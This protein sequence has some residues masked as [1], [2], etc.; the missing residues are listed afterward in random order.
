[1]RRS[2][3]ADYGFR[4]RSDSA[5]TWKEKKSDYYPKWSGM[6]YHCLNA[7][8]YVSNRVLRDLESPII[9]WKQT[10]TFITESYRSGMVR[11]AQRRTSVSQVHTVTF[12]KLR[13]YCLV[14]L[15]S[16]LWNGWLLLVSVHCQISVGSH[17]GERDTV[18]RI[19]IRLRMV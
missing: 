7:V 3:S 10:Y 12:G 9:V 16:W 13:R 6:S 18:G 14:R 5:T 1:M 11:R 17:S 15:K 19:I 4:L 8:V 2:H